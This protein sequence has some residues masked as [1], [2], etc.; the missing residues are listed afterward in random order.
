MYYVIAIVYH[1][2]K[3]KRL[4]FYSLV[5]CN[6]I[7]CIQT[8]KKEIPLKSLPMERL[9]LDDL[10]G[11]RTPADSWRIAGNVYANY[12]QPYHM[13]AAD[14][15]GILICR[16]S[17][18]GKSSD[19]L[20]QEEFTD[21]DLEM[22]IMLSAGSTASILFQSEYKMQLRDS[23]MKAP[24]GVARQ[25]SIT[26]RVASLNA[27]K[28]PGLWQHLEV[29]FKAPRFN[30]TGKKVCSA[31]ITSVT[32][33]G[34]LIQQEVIADTL[35]RVR[36]DSIDTGPLVLRTENGPVAFRNIRYKTYGENRAQLAD[37]QYR[38]YKGLY[39]NHDEPQQ[40]KPVRIGKTDSLT[41]R[42]GDK[43]AQLVLEGK[44]LLPQKGDYIFQLLAAGAARLL[45][46]GK[47][48]ANNGGTR[49]F[50]HPF[51]GMV[52]LQEGEHH[53]QLSYANYDESLVLRY[54]GQH[55][56][57]T[58][59]TTAASERKA[60]QMELMEYPVK[61]APEIQRGF[62]R[63]RNMVETNSIAVGIP[64]GMN[65]AY[66]LLNYSPLSVWRGR[67]IDVS[68]MWE[69]FSDRQLE[70]PLG[71]SL[72]FTGAP[73]IAKEAGNW[74]DI[75]KEAQPWPDS[76][77]ADS[78]IYTNR[79]YRILPNG[80]PVF[81]Y[82]LGQIMVEDYLHPREDGKGLTRDITVKFKQP[83]TEAWCLLA[84]GGLIEKLSDSSYAV[85]DKRYYIE[86]TEKAEIKHSKEKY[87]LLLPLIPAKGDSSVT[88]TYTII[89]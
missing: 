84:S 85:D 76:I 17:N 48:I 61:K 53:F 14:G 20:T 51:Y 72:E 71:T 6:S 9:S 80:L 42:V 57:L 49:D 74:S 3:I 15:K 70:I 25:D 33:N 89:W 78:S 41:Y 69:G 36:V 34:M 65:Y 82:T 21:M 47:E 83:G 7:S 32:L 75:A 86:T 23:W 50:Q 35:T 43:R 73:S 62:L 4:L 54:E 22:D 12:Q 18:M 44:L 11:F 38:V 31:S 19:L 24:G 58:T 81:F 77:R 10:T 40:R 37:I 8:R 29:K 30:S 45:I 88:I 13:E 60:S 66:H 46:D 27:C 5:L 26:E 1:M 67:F 64:G 79:G 28:A 56:P 39:D 16:P 68:E 55:I 63:H 2:K 52:N 87:Q 59:L